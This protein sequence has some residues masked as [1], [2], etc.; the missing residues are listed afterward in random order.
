MD[1]VSLVRNVER[2]L[3]ARWWPARHFEDRYAR[4]ID[5]WNCQTS[6]YELLKTKRTAE[7]VLS[8]RP[9]GA[10]LDVGCGEG[11]LAVELARAGFAVLACDISPS[12]VDRARA[13]CSG[14]A[15]ARVEQRDVGQ[16]PV[17]GC[18]DVIIL[19][20]VMYYL[21]RGRRRRGVFNELVTILGDGGSVVVVD[22]WPESRSMERALRRRSDLRIVREDIWR[23]PGRSYAITIYQKGL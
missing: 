13:R 21:G 17:V 18:F 8:L 10:V 5:P 14:L 7:A 22:P 20:E 3:G 1:L 2:W 4:L 19:A 12:A 6:P 15:N 11:L 9:A 16:Q 23:D